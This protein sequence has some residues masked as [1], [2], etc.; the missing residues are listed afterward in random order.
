MIHSV[1]TK[2]IHVL[3][4]YLQLTIVMININ[5]DAIE[6]PKVCSICLLT[7]LYA[8]STHWAV[9]DSIPGV[10]LS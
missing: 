6:V 2:A 10:C 9:P 5:Y 4:F 1:L 3:Y 7:E 8:I